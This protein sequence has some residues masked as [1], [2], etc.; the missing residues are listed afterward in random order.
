MLIL[1]AV[2]FGGGF[3]WIFGSLF[4]LIVVL[5]CALA[6]AIFMLLG[7]LVTQLCEYF[8]VSDKYHEVVFGIVYAPLM[9]F[10]EDVT[11]FKVKS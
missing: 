1:M 9:C 5:Y 8:G 7:W 3:Y 11:C 6:L 4:V 2:L 10:A